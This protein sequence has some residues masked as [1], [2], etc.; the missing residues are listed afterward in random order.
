MTKMIQ[1]TMVGFLASLLVINLYG[2]APEAGSAYAYNQS[3]K[4]EGRQSLKEALTDL[5]KQ[6]HVSILSDQQLVE[7]Q[8]VDRFLG[9]RSI[10]V[11]LDETLKDLGLSY[12]KVADN[13]Y[14][15]TAK[16]GNTQL[17]EGQLGQ[18]PEQEV[19]SKPFTA[20][21]VD[22]KISG[23]VI[24]ESGEALAGVTVA[25]IGT[26]YGTTTNENGTYE[27]SIATG[28]YT[29]SISFIGFETITQAV[30]VGNE[31]QVLN[32]TLKESVGSLSEVVILGSR[33][34]T[35]RTNIDKPVP[36]DVIQTKEVKAFAQNDI[37]QILNYVAPSF[38][39]NRQTVSDGTDHIDPA[40][41]RGLGPDQVLVLVNGKRRHTTALVNINGTFGRGT[42]GTD[43][44]S[45]P[46]AAIE[47]V[48]V[49]RDG[50]A[51]Q[52][53]SD[54]IAGVINLVLKKNSPLT[55][56][57]TYGQ[58]N[59]SALGRNFSDGGN[60]QLDVSKGFK[61][62]EKGSVNFSG[63]YLDRGYT[64]RGGLDTRPLLYTA[65]PTRRA[66]ETP[67][68]FDARYISIVNP[69]SKAADD[70]RAA[71]AGLDRNNMRVG[72]SDSRN[73]GFFVNGEYAIAPT[74]TL[75]AAA[76][77]TNKTGKAAGFY[78]LP[79]QG[80]QVDISIFPNGF[81]PFINTSINDL[82]LITG[83]KGELGKWDYDISN[84]F[85]RNDI[86]FD[87]T[88]T[89]NASLPT[90]T[91]PTNFDAGQLIFQQNTINLD[92]SRKFDLKGVL[93][94]F[95]MAYGAEFRYDNYQI[96]AGEEL[97][98][99]F[100][101]PSRGVAGIAGQAA[102]AQVFPGYRPSNEL[103]KSRTNTGLYADFEGEFGPKL[104]IGVAGR[105]EN[106]S[107]FG[108][109]FSYKT[110][111]RWKIYKDYALRG[112][113]STGFRAPSLHQRY[114]NNESTQF[115]QGQPTQ[116]LTVNNDNDVVRQFGVGSLSP[117]LSTS[118]SMGLAGK[119]FNQLTFTI[120]AYQI[121]IED[122]IVFSSQYTRER[123]GSG[124]QIPTG[125][126]NQ[127]LNTVDPTGEINSAQFFTNAISTRT[128]GL[129]V[130]LSD[131][132]DLGAK[133]GKLTVTAA[134]NFNETKVENIKGTDVIESDPA[135]KA[136]LFDRLER[137]RYESAVPRNK[138]NLSVNYSFSKWTFLLRSVR[139]G[140][141]GYLNAVDPTIPANNL[142]LEID[143]T[144]SAKWIS[145]I[146]VSYKITK[147]LDFT[148]GAN[149][150]F[151]I[152]PDKAYIDPRNNENNLAS[153]DSG[154]GYTTGRDNT[155]NGRFLYS[156]NVSQFG[157]NG[158]FL[159][160]KITWTP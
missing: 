69:A 140:E 143:Q 124:N 10:G 45:I 54:A 133:R 139:F 107:D 35:A 130:V 123:D 53:G 67:A 75:Y 109:N 21:S 155:S 33:S 128:R 106:Y 43:M 97:S 96:Q 71:A 87:I 147:S 85:G 144:F 24:S 41:L 135:L 114:F 113:L 27:L 111:A 13:F 23:K 55:V 17:N 61:L 70:A 156:R 64:N 16:S 22:S 100:G 88:N 28:N 32:F 34:A 132:F 151:D 127:I 47:R 12:K 108:S 52:Y 48:E 112:G 60:F 18:A 136:R 15:I 152:Y 82:S 39:S 99:S 117:E 36:V 115:V 49:L 129:D 131:K 25:V 31:N 153:P 73:L 58:S 93:S 2:Q 5:E 141:V 154:V 26:S 30:I 4:M 158:R 42:V 145:D 137:S 9:N 83:L 134:A 138:I 86:A 50:A 62:G 37:T 11:A 19:L 149:N 142:P 98:W 105:Y 80:T 20:L 122:R 51:A 121:D 78:R 29:L 1:L 44:N 8:T 84:T 103:D 76:G 126:I 91:S 14:V 65:I 148:V 94:S 101:Q 7:N 63:Q 66:N 125:R 150:L 92:V 77:Y 89:V 3:S 68:A 46:V 57:T 56:S 81:L 119:I 160:A 116:V 120:D 159:F 102:G 90:G 95:N 74:A 79:S 110:I 104:L 146:S 72:N 6:Y 40:S 59:S 118:V 38:N 157:F